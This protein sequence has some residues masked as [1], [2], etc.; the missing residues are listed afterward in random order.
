[1]KTAKLAGGCCDLSLP[2]RVFA[3]DTAVHSTAQPEAD[4]ALADLRD[5]L[6]QKGYNKFESGKLQTVPFLTA[7][8][9]GKA[10]TERY[11]PL[12]TKKWFCGVLKCGWSGER[13]QRFDEHAMGHSGGYPCPFCKKQHSSP[14]AIGGCALARAKSLLLTSSTLPSS[15][16]SS[17]G[18]WFD[19]DD[20]LLDA[21]MGVA[22]DVQA[23]QKLSDAGSQLTNEDDPLG[24]VTGSGLEGSVAG[25]AKRPTLGPVVKLALPPWHRT[26]RLELTIDGRLWI[27]PK[28]PLSALDSRHVCGVSQHG[29]Y[30][31]FAYDLPLPILVEI[32]RFICS[33]HSFTYFSLAV[34]PQ[35]PSN[36]VR[37]VNVFGVT[38]GTELKRGILLS[39]DMYIHLVNLAN[40]ICNM[41]QV[42]TTISG[43]YGSS[44]AALRAHRQRLGGTDDNPA[45]E[46]FVARGKPVPFLFVLTR[47][48]GVSWHSVS[49]IHDFWWQVEGLESLRV[50]DASKPIAGW[51]VDLSRF[52][53]VMAA[54]GD[55]LSID[56]SYRF[57]KNV[58][59]YIARG[60][61]VKIV[62][63][64]HGTA[65]GGTAVLLV[66]AN[67]GETAADLIA[68]LID[69][70]PCTSVVWESKTRVRCMTPASSALLADSGEENATLA[71]DVVVQTKSGGF[72]RCLQ[73]FTYTKGLFRAGV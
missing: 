70:Q 71:R 35:I 37:S 55:V 21:A 44:F 69:G 62:W 72:G 46:S 65:L 6:Q 13:Q 27:P 9:N 2:D 73:K 40:V 41:S 59:I 11:K 10:T 12:K 48:L 53:V 58:G 54:A 57:T 29:S 19:L 24:I 63:P 42:E 28:C 67:F 66:G 18:D 39:G 32:P 47:F 64:W 20:T 22:P 50:H 33:G 56:S 68:V 43:Q 45:L 25:D 15:S 34:Q 51:S 16:L 60:P 4:A 1:L 26:S 17:T 5:A 23:E 31:R 49:L 61:F 52:S 8:Y 3:D 30:S 14:Q 36:A 7:V 38:S